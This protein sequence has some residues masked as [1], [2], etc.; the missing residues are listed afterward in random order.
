M[1]LGT[2]LEYVGS[3]PRVSRA[4]QDGIR[5]FAGRRPRLVERLSG[6]RSMPL[7]LDFCFLFHLL[8]FVLQVWIPPIKVFQHPPLSSRAHGRLSRGLR[9]G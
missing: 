5:E 4:Y 8:S 7:G 9:L 2:R 6:G 1:Q 3:L